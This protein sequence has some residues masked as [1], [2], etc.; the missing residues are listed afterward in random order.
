MP[1]KDLTTYRIG[2]PARFYVAVDEPAELPDVIDQV[3]RRGEPYFVLG[4]GSNI[5]VSDQGFPGTVI[6]LKNKGLAL[7]EDGRLTAAAGESLAA[8]V[9]STVEAGFAGLEWATSVP[10]TIGGAVVGNA[11]A[12]YGAMDQIVRKVTV[13]D[14]SRHAFRTYLKSD[15]GFRYRTSIFK[16]SGEIVTEIEFQLTPGDKNEL[17]R[18]AEQIKEYRFNRHPQE[19]SVGSV[20]KNI[21]D[22]KFIK[23]FLEQYPDAREPYVRRWKSKIPSAYLIEHAGLKGLKIGGAQVAPK[24]SAFLINTGRA[25]AEDIAILAGIIKERVWNRFGYHLREEMRYVGFKKLISLP[26][27]VA[28]ATSSG[29][30]S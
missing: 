3:R 24:H 1:L 6:H 30:N 23:P 16:H 29:L 8:A 18:R 27:R 20:F 26:C 14:P 19:P 10:G 22:Q 28:G 25:R 15:C 2:G 9:A 5:L 13:L 11:G 4:G 21:D 17:R 7:D 12:F